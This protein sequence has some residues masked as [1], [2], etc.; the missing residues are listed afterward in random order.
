MWH[1]EWVVCNA[2]VELW[3]GRVDVREVSIQ[4]ELLVGDEVLVFMEVSMYAGLSLNRFNFI[5]LYIVEY[6]CLYI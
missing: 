4:D 2:S 6:V 1:L 5:I 3:G